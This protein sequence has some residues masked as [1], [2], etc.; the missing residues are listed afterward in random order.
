M[1]KFGEQ[2][3]H[4]KDSKLHTSESVEHEAQRQKELERRKKEED[5]QAV[6]QRPDDKI[7]NWLEVIERTH[8]GHEDDP[9]VLERIKQYYR[10]E[11]V[12]KAEDVPESAFLLE[13]KIARQLGHGTI[14]I[15]DDFKQ[16]KTEQIIGDQSRSLD[17]WLDYLS[18]PDA[19][20]PTWA[21]Y[22]AFK[23]V[24]TMGKFEK[25]ENEITHSESGQF[26][27][28]TKDTVASFPPLNPRAL[29]MAIGAMIE[30][31]EKKEIKSVSQKLTSE[32]FS[33]L[34]ATENFAKIYA[35]FLIEM[36]EYS[37]EGLKET[38]GEWVVYK[39]G[40]ES[41]PDRLV[42][43]LE[44]YPLE[45]CTANIE[46][47]KTHLQGGDFYIYY[48]INQAGEAVIPRLAIRMDGNGIAEV[49]GIAPDQNID[50]YISDIAQQKLNE[51][52][53][54]KAYEQKSADMKRLT[55]LEEKNNSHEEL[56]KDDLLFLYE[57][58]APINGF[59]YRKD[60][61]IKEIIETRNLREDAPLV[62]DCQPQ[63]IAW[64]HSEYDEKVSNK[65]EV[66]AYIGPLFPGIFKLSIER[67][68]TSFPEGKIEQVKMTIGG[69]S[70]LEFLKELDR[71]VESDNSEKK[72]YIPDH[73]WSMMNNPEFVTLEKPEAVDLVR[74]KVSDLGFSQNVTTRDIYIKA[75]ELGLELCPP[76][77]GPR[78]MLDY[79]QV[80]N[81]EQFRGEGFC[82]GMK[83]LSDSN[84][85][86]NV[87]GLD[88]IGD[89][90][91]L[92]RNWA[93]PG[94][95]WSPRDGLCFRSRKLE[96]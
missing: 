1:E 63:E 40:D 34:L 51:F 15:T 7:A 28:R 27:K 48:S 96:T 24:V 38:R 89:G 9:K 58:K 83:P 37:T 93:G 25:Q 95:E 35:Q 33:Q 14:E 79:D 78:L 84:G 45:W 29:A 23:A 36:P 16:K 92:G 17:K 41:A 57:I 59:G 12:I 52:P 69:Q 90:C 54:G 74:L 70:K 94:N 3:L 21:K 2:F 56:T 64:G 43:S 73:V 46:T 80:F 91:W 71:R 60:P 47:A 72:M 32:Q 53:D 75:A 44:G 82:I 86:P 67:V 50:P 87:F 85:N 22:W 76:E 4:K 10:N 81:R 68:Y 13:Q 18:S 61:R 31:I 8:S 42:K 62:L 6:S 65:Q 66:R 55:Q 49:R 11:Y 77:V 5:R 88:R 30:K 19:T 26:Q 20:Y 39:Q